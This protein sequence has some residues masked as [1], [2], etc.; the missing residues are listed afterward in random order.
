MALPR[1]AEE[2]SRSR[3]DG[4]RSLLSARKEPGKYVERRAGGQP[5]ALFQR[6]STLSLAL[7]MTEKHEKA[8][9]AGDLHERGCTELEAV[10]GPSG[11]PGNSQWPF[12][13]DRPGWRSSCQ[14]R[15][16]TTR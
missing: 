6:A 8:E 3:S 14:E 15:L 16:L 5:R 9:R 13:A 12:Q 2:S 10:H 1:H 7:A 11:L 4:Q